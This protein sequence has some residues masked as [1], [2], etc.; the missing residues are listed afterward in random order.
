MKRLSS[1]LI[2]VSGIFILTSTVPAY[3]DS[4]EFLFGYSNVFGA[5][6][7]DPAE[8]YGSVTI[9]EYSNYLNVSIAANTDY[10]ANV[11]NMAWD[12]FLFNLYENLSV[13]TN[14]IELLNGA[15]GN[16]TIV[17]NKSDGGFGA[18]EFL[19]KG[20]AINET[21]NP[22]EFNILITGLTIEDIAVEN[23]DGW[24]FV[25][26]LRDFEAMEGETSTF[27][28]VGEYNPVP[29]PATMLLLGTGIAGLA[30]IA[31]RKRS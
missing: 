4:Q 5:W 14:D 17:Y 12:K 25:G 1:I 3:A 28:A 9:T 21:V 6:S 30:G 24:T 11:N 7:G 2:L 10:F 19:Y 22:L 8:G 16:W 15:D 13:T 31:R 29:E 23:A 18:F 26:H 20:T 27:L